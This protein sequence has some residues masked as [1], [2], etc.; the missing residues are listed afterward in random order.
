MTETK[1]K[2]K[3]AVF[4]YIESEIYDYPDTV[5]NIKDRYQNIMYASSKQDDAGVVK[6]GGVGRPTERIATALMSSTSLARLER[7]ASAIGSSYDQMPEDHKR[8]IQLKYWDNRKLTMEGIASE[9]FMHRNTASKYRKE[10][11]YLVASK[12]GY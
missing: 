1:D 5:Q 11:V 12:L 10:F 9:C 2:L 3:T 4:K 8:V 6:G 7:I